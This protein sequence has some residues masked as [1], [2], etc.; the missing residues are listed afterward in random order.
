MKLYHATYGAYLDSILEQGLIPNYKTNW[1]FSGRYIYLTSDPDIAFYFA[2]TA[3]RA[4]EEYLNDIVI[5]EIDITD[6]DQ[7]KL[8]LDDNITQ[9][10]NDEEEPYSFQYKGTIRPQLLSIYKRVQN[11]ETKKLYDKAM[12]NFFDNVGLADM[13]NP[14]IKEY[15]ELENIDECRGQCYDEANKFVYWLQDNKPKLYENLLDRGLQRVDGF[16]IIDEPEKLPLEFQDLEQD[17]YEEFLN[18]YEDDF[19]PNDPKDISYYIWKYLEEYANEDRLSDFY[20][21]D[22]AWVDIDGFIIDFTW[23]QFKNAIYDTG[24]LIERYEY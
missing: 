4:P 1:D 6:L 12:V 24:N 20:A 11:K 18:L 5:F 14:T 2:E 23:T 3:D 21:F 10:E 16:F 17:E 8:R 7:D 13:L 19:D 15:R 22:H 9:D